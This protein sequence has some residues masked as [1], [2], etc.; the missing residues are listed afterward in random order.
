M[1]N[2]RKEQLKIFEAVAAKDLE[3]RM[4]AHSRE[5]FPKQCAVL[6]E[7][8]LLALV[9]YG[10]ERAK[11]Y[12][13][14]AETDVCKYIDVMFT[15]GKDFDRDPR[16]PWAVRTLNDSNLGAPSARISRLSA[17]ALEAAGGKGSNA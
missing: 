17:E 9:R 14:V 4:V 8:G 15:L 16:Y 2:L 3:Q 1:F 6:D 7:A 13:I 5:R 12:G 10:V 11:S